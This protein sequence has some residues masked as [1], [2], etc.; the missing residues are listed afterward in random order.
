M[1]A[2]ALEAALQLESRRKV[3]SLIISS[4]GIHL[5][6]IPGKLSLPLGVVQYHIKF[7]ED[8]DA[9]KAERE[10]GYVRFFPSGM[11]RKERTALSALRNRSRRRILLHLLASPGATH[12]ELT[13]KIGLSPS[14]VSWHLKKLEESGIIT[15]DNESKNTAYRINDRDVIIRMVIAYRESFFD[16][17]IENFVSMWDV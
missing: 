1:K 4:P 14:T 15:L 7:L 5:R 16:K 17:L 9:I 6:D 8:I 12:E 13:L 2:G 10:A 3:F 11:G